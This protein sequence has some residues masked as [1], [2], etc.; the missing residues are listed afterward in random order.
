MVHKRVKISLF[1]ETISRWLSS[2]SPRR[3]EITLS[4]KNIYIFPSKMGFAFTLLLVLM[5]LTAINY[6]SSLIYLFT[7][8]LGAVF[9]VS[10]WLCFLNMNGLSV[11]SYRIADCFEGELC[12][13]TIE[14]ISSSKPTL[15]IRIGENKEVLT[16]LNIHKDVNTVHNLL[17][18]TQKR[19][20][21]TLDRLRIESTFPFGFIIAW[22]WLKLN[23][24]VLVFPKPIQGYR[25]ESGGA[26][27]EV[28]NSG[29]LSEDLTEL[30]AYQQGD[31][32][33]RI[34]W[35]QL[36]AKNQLIIRHPE[37]GATNSVWLSWSRYA[38]SNIEL[39]LQ[40]LCFDILDAHRKQSSYGLD[41]PGV[42]INPAMGEKHKLDCLKALA[43][44]GSREDNVEV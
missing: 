5:L 28:G 26:D 32:S 38:T 41:I 20:L 1:P 16:E 24:R 31:S 36:A 23:A 40:Y 19:G 4:Q 39:K 8:F 11:S 44:F 27:F 33:L 6:Q 42:L 18:P 43:L 7:F 25:S 21:H 14:F 15:G 12:T 35:K 22:T 34:V 37:Q 30:K 2:R 9:F 29:F 13:Y 3:S 10:I 17:L